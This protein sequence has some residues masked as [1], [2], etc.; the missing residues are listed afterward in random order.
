MRSYYII[1]RDPAV[2][3]G[4]DSNAE[5]IRKLDPIPVIDSYCCRE[6][7]ERDI[8]P[9]AFV[10]R[11]S[12]RYRKEAAKVPGVVRCRAKERARYPS[13]IIIRNC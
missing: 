4:I 7:I 12:V 9:Q 2:A 3:L 8:L 11:V 10:Y 1:V 13:A 5:L 6:A